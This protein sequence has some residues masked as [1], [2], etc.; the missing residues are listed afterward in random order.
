MNEQRLATVSIVATALL[1]CVTIAFVTMV[2][3]AEAVEPRPEYAFTVDVN[4]VTNQRVLQE[5]RLEK[6]RQLHDKMVEK[7]EQR[8]AEEEAARIAEEQ[9]AWEAE[10]AYYAQSYTPSYS[11]GTYYA[12]Y[13]DAY[14]TDGPSHT[15]PG[16]HDGY[17]ETYYNASSHYLASEWT[18]DSE[19]FYHDSNG[20]YVVGV[21]INDV[22]PETGQQYQ[23][24]DVVDT[25]KGEGVVYDYGQGAHVHDFATAW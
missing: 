11:G 12:E 15:M 16:W 17:L 3:P 18:L 6:L 19:G 14:N 4:D 1:I 8:Q 20:R 9:A 13:S 7:Y 5:M 25:G 24:G 2:R 21:D 23:Y 22:N 10:Q